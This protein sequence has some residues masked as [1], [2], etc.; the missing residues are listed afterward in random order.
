MLQRLHLHPHMTCMTTDDASNDR[1]LPP[2]CTVQH[3]LE[4]G[5]EL[6]SVPRKSVLRVL[7]EYCTTD[8]EKYQLLC[9]CR[10]SA[11]GKAKYRDFVETQRLSV[12]ELLSLFPSCAPPLDHLISILPPLALR[13]YSICTSPLVNPHRIG[14]AFSVLSYVLPNT[15]IVRHGVCTHWLQTTFVQPL[16]HRK[17]E[18]IDFTLRR[19]TRNFHLPARLS[20]PLICIGPG[21]GVAPFIG[22]LSHR[23]Q[24]Q[25][26]PG[27]RGPLGSISLYFGCRHER[28]DWIFKHE[29]LAQ[30]E[31]NVCSHLHVA[32][33]RDGPEKRYV[34]HDLV[35]Q[36]HQVFELIDT[37]QAHVY[38][39]GDG[40]KMA[41]D[42]HETLVQIVQEQGQ[43]S[44]YVQAQAYVQRLTEE[45]RY[46]KDIW[47]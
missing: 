14:I 25:S 7:A 35:G 12:P 17:I 42:V 6:T 18:S 24:Q 11:E 33:S 47:S 39:C 3:A 16:A 23:E 9:L 29:M 41:K 5:L 26:C 37:Y 10:K 34:Q 28:H 45:G 38:L 8:E 13:Y 36:S 2:S 19:A 1:R 4:Y 31:S 30:V 43:M 27:S 46:V 21:T 20:C 15:S 32:F 40:K 44:T 22:F